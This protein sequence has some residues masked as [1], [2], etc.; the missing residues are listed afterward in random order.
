[1][2][3]AVVL[4]L[5]VCA[6]AGLHAADLRA[7]AQALAD[8]VESSGGE[9]AA[10]SRYEP[11]TARACKAVSGGDVHALTRALVTVESFATPV[12]ETLSKGA[13]VHL[14]AS[15]GLPPPDLTYGPGRIRL[16]TARAVS[17]GADGATLSLRL[18]DYCETAEIAALVVRDILASEAKAGQT[19]D[20][21]AV[22][23]VAGRY[24]GQQR[25]ASGAEA[26]LAHETYTALVYALYEHYRFA[27][28]RTR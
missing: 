3:R 24:N 21:A 12:A 7:R 2:R 28:L 15:A 8:F 20:L 5:L 11:K 14:F 1:V 27:D 4:L 19:I 23:S 13:L 6:L 16:S 26:A 9:V 10:V 18:L 25:K 17:Q 22:R